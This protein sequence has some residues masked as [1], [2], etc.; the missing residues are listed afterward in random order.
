M[1]KKILATAVFVFALAFGASAQTTEVK[2][3]EG[4]VGVQAVRVNPDI[5]QPNYRF[6]RTTDTLGVNASVTRYFDNS[7]VGFTA[8][9]GANFDNDETDSSLVTGMVGLTAK[10]RRDKTVQPFVRGLVG[11]GR[12]RSN[13]EQLNPATFFDRA[14]TGLAFATGAGLDLQLGKRVGLRLVQVDYLQTRTFGE[15]VNNVR[16]GAGITF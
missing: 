12:I 6:D 5:R 4:Y 13:N 9:V 8:E 7:P 14:D 3:V 1:I 2:T 15:P 10:A 16:F 11:V